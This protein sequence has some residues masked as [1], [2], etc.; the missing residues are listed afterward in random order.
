MSDCHVKILHEKE[1]EYCF[2]ISSKTNNIPPYLLTCDDRI[3]FIEWI[4][5]IKNS[6][7]QIALTINSNIDLNKKLNIGNETVTNSIPINN[8]INSISNNNENSVAIDKSNNSINNV[9]SDHIVLSSLK[10]KRFNDD[11]IINDNNNNNNIPITRRPSFG[12]INKEYMSPRNRSRTL[13]FPITEDKNNESNNNN[14]NNNNNGSKMRI[15]FSSDIIINNKDR[16]TILKEKLVIMKEKL[17][18]DFYQFMETI[19]N[20]LLRLRLLHVSSPSSF[21]TS[22]SAVHV[23]QQLKKL[24]N[25]LIHDTVDQLLENDN[26]KYR[27]LEIQQLLKYP[28]CNEFIARLLFIFSPLSRLMQYYNHECSNINLNINNNNFNNNN[29]IINNKLTTP[30]HSPHAINAYEINETNNDNIVSNFENEE[31]TSAINKIHNEID[32]YILFEIIRK[33][34]IKTQEVITCRIC[35]EDISYNDIREHIIY[36]SIIFDNKITQLTVE[37]Q[38][39]YLT[40]LFLVL[41]NYK[42]KIT[43][44]LKKEYIN[45]NPFQVYSNTVEEEFSKKKVEQISKL[46]EIVSQATLNEKIEEDEKYRWIR[47][48]EELVNN[49]KDNLWKTVGDKLKQL[50]IAKVLILLKKDDNIVISNNNNNNV[51]N[52]I[53]KTKGPAIQDFDIIK[54]ISRGAFG[55]VYLAQKKRT[56]DYYAIK[57][58]KKSDMVRKNMVD[59]VLIERDILA[60]AE[61]PWVVKLFYA[62]QSNINLYL[63]MEF[64]C[65]GDLAV[66][67]FNRMLL[68]KNKNIELITQ[69]PIF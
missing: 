2:K 6:I 46:I 24:T 22:I 20:T 54:P 49:K 52:K 39:I 16:M 34:E 23:L 3:Q 15:Q 11:F 32:N 28:S 29:N 14:N 17:N 40:K 69:P 62:F 26:Y 30:P 47:E 44:Q 68:L 19:K 60:Q 55:R 38:L 48:I 53:I 13:P 56:M 31:Y 12:N 10:Y 36:C 61:N 65:G 1:K 58:I 9:N 27:I 59:Q 41:A 64:C 63:V 37:S 51:N 43:Q 45:N 25:L 18:G 21:Q 67:N 7:K 35:E 8:Q 66:S 4:Q 5:S 50:I 42:I 33:K 57:I